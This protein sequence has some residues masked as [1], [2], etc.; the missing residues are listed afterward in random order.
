MPTLIF[1]GEIRNSS[2]NLALHNQV[3]GIF[4]SPLNIP[5][6]YNSMQSLFLETTLVILEELSIQCH[7]VLYDN[8]DWSNVGVIFW[9]KGGQIETRQELT[10][11]L[12]ATYA[13]ILFLGGSNASA[14]QSVV[15]VERTVFYRERAAGMYSELPYAFAHVA[16]ETIYVAIQTFIY[17]LLLYSMIGYEWEVD[18]FFY[19][20]YFIFMCFTYFS[21]YGMMV[22]ALTPGHQIAAIVMSF[23]LSFWNLFSGFL[24]PRPL[25][26]VW[27][28]WYYWGSPVA[29][30]IYGIFA[31]QFADKKTILHVPDA[32]ST[33]VDVFLKKDFG[34]DHDFLIPVVLAHVGWV[35]LFFFVF[36][37]GIKFLNFQ[38]R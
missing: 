36:A 21:M 35:L 7:P 8:Y 6:A 29:W 31:S 34:Y 22:V 28:R 25:I 37:Y 15:A 2:K 5:R 4:T 14:V 30:T 9:N 16:V 1:I 23:F 12:G 27:W 18:K 20:Y 26:P 33:T 10:N 38:R 13:A 24:I 32:P 3:P 17:T 11:L 19:F